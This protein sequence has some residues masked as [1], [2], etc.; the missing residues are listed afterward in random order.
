MPNPYTDEPECHLCRDT[1]YV[2]ATYKPC[3]R[4]VPPV[5]EAP[6]PISTEIPPEWLGSTRTRKIMGTTTGRIMNYPQVAAQIAVLREAVLAVWERN[7]GW[8]PGGAYKEL[9]EALGVDVSRLS[10]YDMDVRRLIGSPN[11][12]YRGGM[13]VLDGAPVY[14]PCIYWVNGE[15]CNKTEEEHP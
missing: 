1:G 5:T 2:P 11:H 12:R 3:P 15:L 4:C 13:S 8:I 14:G 9:A 10:H 7:G 6:T